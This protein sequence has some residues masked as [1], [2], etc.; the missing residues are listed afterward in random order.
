VFTVGVQGG[1]GAG[2]TAGMPERGR[3]SLIV[4]PNSR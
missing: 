2:K 1:S 3:I 4:I